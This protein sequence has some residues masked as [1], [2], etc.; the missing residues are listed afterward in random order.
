MSFFFPV[1][2]RNFPSLSTVVEMESAKRHRGAPTWSQQ[3]R[4]DASVEPN[5]DNQWNASTGR[6]PPPTEAR[7]SAASR[8]AIETTYHRDEDKQEAM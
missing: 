4:W 8:A 3:K 2:S 5:R 6:P 7:S 1:L